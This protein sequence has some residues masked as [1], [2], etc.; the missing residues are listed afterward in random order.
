MKKILLL[1]AVYSLLFTPAF[2]AIE[3][4]DNSYQSPYATTTTD[5][6]GGAIDYVVKDQLGASSTNDFGGIIEGS[7]GFFER[8]ADWLR[9]KANID[10]IGIFKGIGG[11]FLKIFKWI[12]GLIL[13]KSFGGDV[14]A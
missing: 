14:P 4:G 5:K 12:F 9:E 10:L 2:A 7:K 13:Q 11:F 3:Y 1:F 6:V 8:I